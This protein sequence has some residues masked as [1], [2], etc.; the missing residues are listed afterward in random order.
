M[1]NQFGIASEYADLEN[2][3]VDKLLVQA[4][5]IATYIEQLRNISRGG[6]PN[7][8]EI[9]SAIRSVDQLHPTA[10]DVDG[11]R[12]VKFL[13]LRLSSGMIVFES[14]ETD[15]FIVDRVEYGD[16][17]ERKVSVLSFSLEEV[18]HFDRFLLALGL[19]DR[20]MSAAV[21]E[22]T[23]VLQP[24][25][26][27]TA[28]LTRE[29]REKAK[30]LFRYVNILLYSEGGILMFARCAVHFHSSKVHNENEAVFRM[31]REVQVYE[32]EGFSKTLSVNQSGSAIIAES[33]RGVLHLEEQ[34]NNLKIYV[35]RDQRDRRRCYANQ[36]PKDLMG[37]LGIN[38]PAARGI[39]QNVIRSEM[40]ILDD[41]LEEDGIIQVDLDPSHDDVGD[42][43]ADEA[44]SEV[45]ASNLS[46]GNTD[47]RP[48]PRPLTPQDHGLE[49]GSERSGSLA[50]S[51]VS[52]GPGRS[53]PPSPQSTGPIRHPGSSQPLSYSNGDRSQHST[54]AGEH[55]DRTAYTR[56]LIQVSAAARRA[57]FDMGTLD[58]AFAS[59]P[60]GSAALSSSPF[61][62]RRPNQLEHDI[63]IGAAG[64]L[65]VSHMP[66]PITR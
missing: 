48:M 33:A 32:S 28:T 12:H 61:G 39:F 55:E 25:T 19:E 65:F 11:L 6:S 9:Q 35:P 45:V 52:Y 22:H 27:P 58:E 14:P 42:L 66:I 30:A 46:S 17:F 56:L 54:V 43:G 63:R 7:P 10:N 60:S 41:I 3:F 49:T 64:E 36:L 13:P 47:A 62:N 44:A 37:H 20:Y 24:A 50:P 5:T 26:N 1:G 2:L 15:F 8:D 31:L 51:A 40:D 21:E 53:I 34:D 4:P 16:A 18:R 38:D 59:R 57:N 29:F 23:T